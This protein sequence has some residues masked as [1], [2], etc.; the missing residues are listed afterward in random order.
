MMRKWISS[1]M[2]AALTLGALATFAL[3]A[4]SAEAQLLWEQPYEE[5]QSESRRPRR[6]YEGSPAPGVYCSYRREPIRTC[7]YE[8]GRERC[9]VTS[10]R[11][12]QWCS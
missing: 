11:L 8:R 4:G 12:V 10:W 2:V 3:T 5:W 1:S 9:K 6:G 7:K